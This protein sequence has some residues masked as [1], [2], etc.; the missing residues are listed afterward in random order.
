MITVYDINLVA[1]LKG[2]GAT[3]YRLT[4]NKDISLADWKIL[5]ED[6][7]VKFALPTKAG[8]HT[9]YIQLKN[10]YNISQIF[11][12]TINYVPYNE[13]EVIP[14]TTPT[15][16]TASLITTTGFRIS[17]SP[18]I[19]FNSITY[20]VYRNDIKVGDTETT[21]YDFTG[22]QAD[23]NHSITIRAIDSEELTSNFSPVLV[24]KTSASVPVEET[25][26][27]GNVI[28]TQVFS[29]SST[30]VNTQEDCQIDHCFVTLYNKSA[31]DIPLDNAR[32]YWKYSDY[33]TWHEVELSGI[34][35]SGKHFLIRGSKLTGTAP[36]TT[37]IMDW[38]LKQVDLECWVDWT[39]FID[40]NPSDVLNRDFRMVEWANTHNFLYIGSKS[41]VVYLSNAT[42]NIE[43]LPTNP[44]LVKNTLPNYVDLVGVIGKDGENIIAETTPA[45]NLKKTV[46]ADRKWISNRYQDTD[47]NS[48]DFSMTSTVFTNPQD[49]AAI[50]KNSLS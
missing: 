1:D 29:P 13:G 39:E 14:P 9:V 7:T 32:L 3:H 21:T 8:E 15:G 23:T 19:G 25:S 38:S 11:S 22:L 37:I 33:P 2:F 12:E 43:T 48:A 40:P 30:I 34:I 41:G 28:I 6:Y 50:I 20:E 27:V 45:G 31:S 35:K 47:D 24:V 42:E 10:P 16:L 44:W 46:I 36:G 4:V 5:N 17:W 49:L 26:L 18:S